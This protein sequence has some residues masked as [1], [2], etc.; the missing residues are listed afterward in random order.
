MVLCVLAK[1]KT[2]VRFPSPAQGF[3][4]C[5]V[6]LTYRCS[7]RIFRANDN[8]PGKN[9]EM[10]QKEVRKCLCK[11]PLCAKCLF[12]NCKDDN[13]PTH[14]LSNKIRWKEKFFNN[15]TN[16]ERVALE[17]EIERL[18]NLMHERFIEQVKSRK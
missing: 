13:C 12:S 17:K 7:Q 1:D 15:F 4:A 5:K 11:T 16:K 18:K 2:R 3:R 6:Y 14:S 8:G 9:K 10:N